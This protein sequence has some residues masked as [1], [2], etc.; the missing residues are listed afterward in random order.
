MLSNAK[1]AVDKR[2]Q[3]GR[4]L[5]LASVRRCGPRNQFQLHGRIVGG[6]TRPR[7][8]LHAL[9]TILPWW[10]PLRSF[11]AESTRCRTPLFYGGYW[12]RPHRFGEFHQPHGHG[13]DPHSGFHGPVGGFHG[14]GVFLVAEVAL[15]AEPVGAANFAGRRMALPVKLYA[16]FCL[17]RKRFY[18]TLFR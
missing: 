1:I 12:G 16:W 14:G 8:T 15:V 9:A 18:R 13:F 2:P 5:G 4:Q 17:P 10:K 7:P 3:S 11:E 6:S